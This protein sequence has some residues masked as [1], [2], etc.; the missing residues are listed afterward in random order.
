LTLLEAHGITDVLVNLHHLPEEVMAFL[1]RF[2]TKL[3]VTTVYEPALLGS[4]GTVWQNRPFVEGDEDFLIVYGDNL[5]TVNLRKMMAFH[6]RRRETL[7]LGATLTDRPR[8]KGTVVVGPA[9]EAVRFEE[10]ADQPQSNLANAGIYVANQRLFEYMRARAGVY[11][12]GHDVLPDMVPDIAV[13]FIDEFLMD[14]GTSA[15]Y[16]EAQ[17][18]WPGLGATTWRD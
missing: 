1:K 18:V 13:Y 2:P 15:A 16:A 3:N 17:R 11:D 12:F 8:E 5:T 9:G 10:K 7:S 14:I 4:A 6:R